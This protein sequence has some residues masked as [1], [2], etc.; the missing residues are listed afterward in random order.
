[1]KVE[2]GEEAEDTVRASGGHL[3]QR[4]LTRQALVG[5]GVHASGDLL[6]STGPDQAHQ[7]RPR[8]LLSG[9]L[10]RVHEARSSAMRRTCV[11]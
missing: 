6:E 3:R 10:A 11:A 9:E 2:G 7:R 5:E 4:V 1:V 8:D